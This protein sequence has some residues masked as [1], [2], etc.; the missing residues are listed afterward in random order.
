ML[1]TPLL[2]PMQEVYVGAFPPSVSFTL[3]AANVLCTMK[4]KQLRC[5]TQLNPV[6]QRHRGHKS[7][8]KEHEVPR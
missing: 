3:S 5:V 8:I 4:L 7:Y 1:C 6:N 2:F